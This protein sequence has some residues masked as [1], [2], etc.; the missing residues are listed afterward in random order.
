MRNDETIRAYL[1]N[2]PKQYVW[3]RKAEDT[4]AITPIA[5]FL[6]NPLDE[7]EMVHWYGS[8]TEYSDLGVG[9]M[10]LVGVTAEELLAAGFTHV[11]SHP[12]Y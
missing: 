4:E 2:R 3:R 8:K 12:V 5:E 9:N 10:G 11:H 6:Q 7:N 1:A